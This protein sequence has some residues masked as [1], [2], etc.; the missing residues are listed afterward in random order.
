MA[1]AKVTIKFER[2]DR[3]LRQMQLST[4]PASIAAF[5]AGTVHPRLARRARARFNSEGDDAVGG[6]WQPLSAATL[7][8]KANL[9]FRDKGKNRRTDHLMDSIV[10][11][12]PVLGHNGY[13][14]TLD[15]PGNFDRPDLFLRNLQAA[16][17]LRGPARPVVGVSLENDVAH[18]LSSL[19]AWVVQGKGSRQ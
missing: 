2:V 17:Q 6:T 15:F 7:E 16:G 4:S 14:T 12:R 8:I 19:Q 18:M 11:S 5:L 3:M 10:E 13:G 1:D 9:G